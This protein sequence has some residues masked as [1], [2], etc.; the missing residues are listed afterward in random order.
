MLYIYVF[1]EIAYNIT[2]KLYH[3]AN[4]HYFLLNSSGPSSVITLASLPRDNSYTAKKKHYLDICFWYKS[5]WD[6]FSRDQKYLKSIV[7]AKPEAI[8]FGDGSQSLYTKGPAQ[9]G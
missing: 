5:A 7:K 8:D 3:H 1:K 4:P 6:K 9:Q 2:Q